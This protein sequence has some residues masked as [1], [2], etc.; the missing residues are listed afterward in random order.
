MFVKKS[1]GPRIVTL[2]DGTI[3][4]VADLP[5]P[6]AR[7]VASRKAVVVNAVLHGLINRDEAIRRYDLSDEEFDGWLA[8]VARHGNE[9]LKVT[10]VQ[11][12]RRD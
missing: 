6:T 10:A 12:F 11:R 8:A 4:S 5:K 3:L 7:W 2:P 1:T 9:A